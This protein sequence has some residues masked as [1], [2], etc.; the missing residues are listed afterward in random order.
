MTDKSIWPFIAIDNVLIL[1]EIL[2]KI[3]MKEELLFLGY[4]CFLSSCSVMNDKISLS[5]NV[6]KNLKIH[7]S[8]FCL[9]VSL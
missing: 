1:V 7:G 3:E 9:F 2:L 4:F 6:C 8:P 5:K